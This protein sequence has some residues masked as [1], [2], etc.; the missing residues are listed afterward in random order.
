MSQAPTRKVTVKKALMQPAFEKGYRDAMN[1]VG[2]YENYEKISLGEQ[3]SYERGRHFYFAV[4][5]VRLKQ[6][7]GI[8]KTAIAAYKAVR[9][10][11]VVL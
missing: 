3:W 7:N 2:F 10:M 11:R 4:G 6:G 5:K 1:G 9:A 8:S